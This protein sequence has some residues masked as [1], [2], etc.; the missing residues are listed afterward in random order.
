[1]SPSVRKHTSAPVSRTSATARADSAHRAC[2]S[3]RPLSSETGFDEF[4]LR[5]FICFA[6]MV[7]ATLSA[8][9]RDLGTNTCRHSPRILAPLTVI[10]S[11][12]AGPDAYAEQG[13][14][15]HDNKSP[16]IIN[17]TVLDETR[18]SRNS[19]RRASRT[20]SSSIVR[21]SKTKILR[22]AG[23]FSTM[24]SATH[25]KEP[26]RPRRTAILSDFNE[27]VIRI[28]VFFVCADNL[29][30]GPIQPK[31]SKCRLDRAYS[32]DHSA[33]FSS[34]AFDNQSGQAEDSGVTRNQHSD[35]LAIGPLFNSIQ[36][37]FHG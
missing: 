6:A 17:T 5:G 1:M 33:L 21:F 11:G 7:I 4:Q 14:C 16:L 34:E 15:F 9:S 20:D 3:D 29:G 10:K 32:G 30:V 27:R 12:V 19:S 23:A 28:G 35:I 36:R 24:W 13:S 26:A 37:L 25:R 22:S 2:N 18:R 31:S 8:S